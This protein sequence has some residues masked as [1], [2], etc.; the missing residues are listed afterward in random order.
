MISF[1]LGSDVSKLS[2]QGICHLLT[3]V[4]TYCKESFSEFPPYESSHLDESTSYRNAPGYENMD[5]ENL[6]DNADEDFEESTM[7]IGR[8]PIPGHMSK[9]FSEFIDGILMRNLCSLSMA[10]S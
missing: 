6:Y 2:F 9:A 3:N 1:P 8:P 10:S 4:A 5:M 7:E